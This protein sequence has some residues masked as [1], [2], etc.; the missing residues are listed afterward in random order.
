MRVRRHW[1]GPLTR[2][3]DAHAR[4]ALHRH[5]RAKLTRVGPL[6]TTGGSTSAHITAMPAVEGT[7]ATDANTA[8]DAVAFFAEDADGDAD[9]SR[10]WPD[11]HLHHL[12]PGYVPHVENLSSEMVGTLIYPNGPSLGDAVSGDPK[13]FGSW[14]AFVANRQRVCGE[15]S[16]V[17][18]AAMLRGAATD[19][20]VAGN[21]NASAPCDEA[22]LFIK[23]APA[24]YAFY[25]AA[26]L[27]P[28][29]GPPL[30]NLLYEDLR[31][32]DSKEARTRI[33]FAMRHVSVREGSDPPAPFRAWEMGWGDGLFLTHTQP[34]GV[35]SLKW[36]SHR[37]ADGL[38]I[39]GGSFNHVHY[40]DTEVWLVLGS[41]ADL[42]LASEEA[43]RDV[44]PGEG[45]VSTSRRNRKGGTRKV[46]RLGQGVG[47]A[48]VLGS[49]L[50]AAQADAM[51]TLAKAR[52]AVAATDGARAAVGGGLPREPPR[53][54]CKIGASPNAHTDPYPRFN[55]AEVSA[56]DE[57]LRGMK[58][59]AG[60]F[61]TL[62][63]FSPG[64]HKAERKEH[65]IFKMYVNDPRLSKATLAD[66]LLDIP[67]DR[68]RLFGNPLGEELLESRMPPGK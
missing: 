50:G 23:T 32:A 17:R 27:H 57:V 45:L 61:L 37:V 19:A 10:Y 6:V 43:M 55:V 52:A 25:P 3:R 7:L 20:A 58:V 64:A 40:A 16:R 41:A 28:K 39:V 33:T 51:A 13:T 31:P 11:F 14:N 8:F 4:A 66:A 18:V 67:Q 62:M 54:L 60:D 56:C 46:K 44:G 47:E 36:H 53:V 24:G 65:A 30:L 48:V 15:Q 68:M 22:G 21:F 9:S 59:R 35:P 49:G 12:V 63:S 42:G 34:P 26:S 5:A 1:P 38:T 2:A 29:Y